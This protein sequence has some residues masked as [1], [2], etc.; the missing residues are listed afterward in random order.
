M[1]VALRPHGPQH[2]RFP[3]SSLSP[4][5][6]SISCNF[7]KS[8]IQYHVITLLLIT[9]SCNYM[10]IDCLDDLLA[11]ISLG[12][13]SLILIARLQIIKST[14][15]RTLIFLITCDSRNSISSQ[16]E[17]LLG[18]NHNLPP[19]HKTMS[20]WDS[21]NTPQTGLHCRWEWRLF[22]QFFEATG[23]RLF[24]MFTSLIQKTHF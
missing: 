17:P 1:T 4:R 20:P 8:L 21:K 14:T 24:D 12:R 3:C 16:K 22:Q 10:Q 2:I 15:I 19:T 9:R 23:L 18:V 6:C 5:V 7:Y 13:F 11:V